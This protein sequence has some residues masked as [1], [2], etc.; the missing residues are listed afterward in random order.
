[1]QGVR[2]QGQ[3][4]PDVHALWQRAAGLGIP[5]SLG[6]GGQPEKVHRMRN[7]GLDTT[8]LLLRT[9]SRAGVAPK[10]RPR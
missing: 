9:T 6:S 2:L 10:T 1:M 3:A 5:I 8:V 4:E 7:V